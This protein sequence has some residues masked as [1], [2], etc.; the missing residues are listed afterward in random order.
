MDG[1]NG[2]GWG[3]MLISMGKTKV[4]FYTA[5]DLQRLQRNLKIQSKAGTCSWWRMS[6]LVAGSRTEV[7][8]LL[9][10]TIPATPFCS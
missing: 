7:Q 6:M 5:A 2:E 8:H 9:W 4:K 10:L 3:D 1:Q